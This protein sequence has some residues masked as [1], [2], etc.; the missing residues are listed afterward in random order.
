LSDAVGNTNWCQPFRIASAGHKLDIM[1]KG[2][3]V[4]CMHRVLAAPAAH[5]LAVFLKSRHF[6][7][8]SPV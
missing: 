6:P 4:R 7:C 5:M 2:K 3:K 8:V 1:L